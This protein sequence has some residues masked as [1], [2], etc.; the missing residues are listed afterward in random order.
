MRL[1]GALAVGAVA[2]GVL[3]L[4]G[5]EK[6]Y[7]G[8]TVWS[9]TQSEHESALCWSFDPAV[10]IDEEK[11]AT[12]LREGAATGEQFPEIQVIGGNTIGISVDPVVAEFGW[13]PSVQGQDLVSV[14][15][16][17]TYW[18]F[19]LPDLQEIPTEGFPLELRSFGEDGTLRGLW[20]FQVS[21]RAGAE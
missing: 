11:C 6:P 17:T 1:R 10:G 19:T 2:A 13:Q 14:P 20:A 8:A 5:C 4:T 21:P 12:A 3:A 18:R 7:P 9:G 16:T 15:L